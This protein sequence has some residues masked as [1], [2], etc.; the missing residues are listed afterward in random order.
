MS[1][2]TIVLLFLLLIVL[3]VPLLIGMGLTSIIYLIVEQ[4]PLNVLAHRMLNSVNSFTLLAVPLFI[5]AGNLMNTSG[6]SNRIFDFAKMLVGR[7]RG[8]LAQVNIIASLIFSGIS[9]AALADVGGLGNIEIQA[10]K[11]QGYD[12]DLAASITAASATIGPIFPPSIPLIIYGAVAEISGIRLLIAGM[13]PALIITIFSMLQI[14]YFAKKYDYPAGKEK[15]DL[16]LFLSKTGK[17]LPALLTPI[18][19]IVGLLSGVFSP[20]EVAAFTVFYAIIIGKFVYKE[21][22]WKMVI[23]MGKQS[24]KASASILIII[25]AASI[26]AWVLTVE[27]VPTLLS[28]F[29]FSISHDPLILLLLTN[30]LLLIVGMIIEPIAAILILTPILL[31]PLTQA[32]VDPIHLGVVMVL[33]LMVGLLTPPVGMSLY[34]VSVVADSPV[35]KVI[36]RIIPF[37]L[38]I[39]AALLLVTIWPNLSTWLPE[40]IFVN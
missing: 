1:G 39:L 27:Q 36:K 15:F 7:V 17:A 4:I 25:S 28:N 34:M 29:M 19:L 22:S 3:G 32:G 20:T 16:K 31:P 35:E 37:L 13:I 21:L 40:I 18:I 12:S 5:F 10:M 38:P 9:G 6:I 8:G 11:D 30:V 23:D 33:N 2:L 14:A 26:F 24:V